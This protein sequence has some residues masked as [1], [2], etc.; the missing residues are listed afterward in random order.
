VAA[1][2]LIASARRQRRLLRLAHLRSVVG[3]LSSIN[4]VVGQYRVC[5]RSL[6]D[7][8]SSALKETSR[9]SRLASRGHESA[10][11]GSSRRLIVIHVHPHLSS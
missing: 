6:L 11:V 3:L 10:L 5:L 2:S 4:L 1:S 9:G 7:A 8:G